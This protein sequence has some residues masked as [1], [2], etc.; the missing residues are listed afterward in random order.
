MKILLSAAAF[1][2]LF[3]SLKLSGADPQPPTLPASTATPIETIVFLRHGEKPDREIG[4]LNC[5]G[6]N[7]ALALPR[8]LISKFGRPD[9]IF[10]PAPARLS[11]IPG[12]VGYNYLRPLATIEPTAIELGMPVNA[13]F[14]YSDIDGLQSELTGKKYQNAL[15]FVAWEHHKLEKVVKQI[16]SKFHG[17]PDQVPNWKGK[18][19]DSLYI[20]R[21]T[22]RD[23]KKSVS[24]T[25][26]HEGLTNLSPDCPE[27]EYRSQE[28][29]FRSCKSK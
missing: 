18:D 9:Y 24:F 25:Q 7:R 14:N 29:G 4:Q 10:A 16:V 27:T 26:D 1:L 15:I 28:S 2:A 23:G 11:K 13:D 21:I 6:L 5:Q 8:V 17:D 19:F 12:D 22:R 20:V 3:A